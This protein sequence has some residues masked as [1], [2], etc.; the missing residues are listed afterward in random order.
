MQPILG[1][2]G[3]EY[4]EPT[5]G[6][7]LVFTTKDRIRWAHL[8]QHMRRKGVSL[9]IAERRALQQIYQQKNPKLAYS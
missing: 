3:I 2:E 1:P 9:E 7:N 5:G 4:L 6:F 8:V